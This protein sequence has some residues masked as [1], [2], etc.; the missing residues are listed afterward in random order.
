MIDP[1]I[2]RRDA[3]MA[4]IV[5]ANAAGVV[6]SGPH[7]IEI[8]GGVP[9]TDAALAIL[10]RYGLVKTWDRANGGNDHYG[11]PPPPQ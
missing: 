1:L 5:T 11:F 4:E 3:A 10:N 6:G 7:E 9:A 8:L 2:A